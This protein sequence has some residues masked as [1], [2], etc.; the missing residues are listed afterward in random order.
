MISDNELRNIENLAR[1]RLD[2]PSR[3]KFRIQ[4]SRIIEFVEKLREVDTSAIRGEKGE[5]AG[6]SLLRED[7][8]RRGLSPEEALASS[9]RKE[10]GQFKIPPVIEEG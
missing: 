5:G 10:K 3:E 4:L 1:L 9:P 6:A 8:P 7:E 2:G